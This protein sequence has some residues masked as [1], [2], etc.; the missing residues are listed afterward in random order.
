MLGNVELF[1]VKDLVKLAE[2]LEIETITI[3]QVLNNELLLKR[4]TKRK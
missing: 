3:L 4:K 1:V 2:S